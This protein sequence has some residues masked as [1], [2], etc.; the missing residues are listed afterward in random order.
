MDLI[1]GEKQV[2]LNAFYIN[3][4]ITDVVDWGLL[5]RIKSLFFVRCFHLLHKSL[6]KK[7]EK[8][9]LY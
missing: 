6:L 5:H 3:F 8:R 1:L 7:K 4:D 2:L 9:K